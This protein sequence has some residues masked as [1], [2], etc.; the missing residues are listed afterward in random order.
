[1]HSA[2]MNRSSGLL[3]P[4]IVVTED[5]ELQAIP[6]FEIEVPSSSEDENEKPRTRLRPNSFRS[7]V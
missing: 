4:Q 6:T 1:M 2:R 7:A 3:V 5:H